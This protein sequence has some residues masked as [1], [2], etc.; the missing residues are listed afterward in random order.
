M[1][2]R[3]KCSALHRALVDH[4]LSAVQVSVILCRLSGA[5]GHGCEFA[6]LG[7]LTGVDAGVLD[8]AVPLL[9]LQNFVTVSEASPRGSAGPVLWVFA[10]EH[11]LRY[12]AEA[13]AK[14]SAE[15][16]VARGTGSE[17]RL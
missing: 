2:W 16:L 4:G 9:G 15:T 3:A 14:A 8:R 10:T 6:R 17:E 5:R 1:L 11:G 7:L 12:A 13:S